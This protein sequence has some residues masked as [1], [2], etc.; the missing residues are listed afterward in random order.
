MIGVSFGMARY[1]FGLLAPEIRESFALSSG[2][3]GLLGAGSYVAY[4][5]ASVAAGGLAERLGARLVVGLGGAFA[6]TGMLIAGLAATPVV[7]FAGLL[8]AGASPGLVFPPLSDVVARNLAPSQRAR[9][10]SAISSGTGWGVALAA[11][12]AVFA[13]AQ[14]RLAWLSFAVL[15]LLAACWALAV[16]PRRGRGSLDSGVEPVRLHLRWFLCPRSRPLLLSA[17]A[18]GLASSVLWTF[19]VDR[20]ISAGGLSTAAGSGFL[21]L[22]GIASI[23]GSMG[24]DAAKLLGG[25]TVLAISLVAEATSLVALGLWPGSLVLALSAGVLFGLSYNAAVAISVIWSADVFH[26][27]PSAG[28]AAVMVMQAVGLLLGPPLWGVLA[29]QFGFLLVFCAAAVVLPVAAVSWR[30]PQVLGES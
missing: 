14:W 5:I 21:A 8:V 25:G 17:L 29:D 4:L 19:G 28:L 15:G 7:L 26:D 10:L 1:G 6:I 13:G 3:L 2:A 16:L 27:R 11:P 12:L 20:V 24:G 22:V 9:I 18:I 30:A 23:G